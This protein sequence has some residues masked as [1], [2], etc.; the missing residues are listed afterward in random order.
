MRNNSQNQRGGRC[1]L[2]FSWKLIILL[3]M[4]NLLRAEI[5]SKR[6]TFTPPDMCQKLFGFMEKTNK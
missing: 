4:P 1:H 2:L 3:S 5:R 6:T